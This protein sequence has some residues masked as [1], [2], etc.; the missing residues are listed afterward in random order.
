MAAEKK[1]D[2]SPPEIKYFDGDHAGFQFFDSAP[3]FAG[4]NGLIAVTLTATR[5]IPGPEKVSIDSVVV[6]HL[7]T[8]I[9]GAISLR[10]AINSALL[11][12]APPQGGT[13]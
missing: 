10:D 2:P 11:L 1:S 3:A 6:G 13:N 5:Y 12:A 9:Q 4:Y 8:N 7:R